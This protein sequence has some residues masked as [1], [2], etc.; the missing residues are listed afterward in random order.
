MRV[1]KSNYDSTFTSHVTNVTGGICERKKSPPT[2]SHI[3]SNPKVAAN[4]NNSIYVTLRFVGKIKI[5][6]RK[7]FDIFYNVTAAARASSGGHAIGDPLL[8]Q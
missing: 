6:T 4:R 3:N 2:N 7:S 5:V 8:P 1:A